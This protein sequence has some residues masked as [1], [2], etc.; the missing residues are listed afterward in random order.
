MTILDSGLETMNYNNPG[1]SAIHDANMQLIDK[2]LAGSY[3]YYLDGLQTEY[4]SG[5][6]VRI[7]V[8]ACRDD[9]NTHFMNL[10][11][12]QDVNITAS[13][14]N[15]LDTGSESS[16]TWYYLWLIYNLTSDTV[17]GLLSL[18]A[19]SPTMPSGYTKKRLIGSVRNSASSAFVN[20][21]GNWL[22]RTK[23]TELW[24]SLSSRLVLSGGTATVFTNIDLSAIVPATTTRARLM[25]RNTAATGE[26]AVR[27]DGHP[28]ADGAVSALNEDTIITTMTA[29][30]QIVEYKRVVPAAGSGDIYVIGYE[31]EF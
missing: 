1:W 8:G 24:S 22:G 27:P 28:S 13:G 20:F 11:S 17:A 9:G 10:E 19:S 30:G 29:P 31:E 2:I 6:V 26:I 21:S 18:S 14:A 3:T 25:I 23:V 12:Q 5:N 16:N 15:G 7:N 4:V